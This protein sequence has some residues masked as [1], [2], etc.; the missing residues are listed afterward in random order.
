MGQS[1]RPEFLDRRDPAERA[2]ADLMAAWQNA[3]DFR[4]A[5]ANA[6]VTIRNKFFAEVMQDYRE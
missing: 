5:W 3:A 6:P 2:F 1:R 4:R